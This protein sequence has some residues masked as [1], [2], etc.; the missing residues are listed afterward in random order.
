MSNNLK[1]THS[2]T[3]FKKVAISFIFFFQLPDSVLEK[4]SKDDN[5]DIRELALEVITDIQQLRA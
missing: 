5:K 3:V 2:Y 4:L 1:V